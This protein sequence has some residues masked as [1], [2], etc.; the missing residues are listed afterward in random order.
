MGNTME[1]Y[2]MYCMC[3]NCMK[4]LQKQS[5]LEETGASLLHARSYLKVYDL[6]CIV[7]LWIDTKWAKAVFKS[8]KIAVQLVVSWTKATWA[9]CTLEVFNILQQCLQSVSQGFVS[10]WS[11]TGT[12]SPNT[13][14]CQKILSQL[15]WCTLECQHGLVRACDSSQPFLMTLNLSWFSEYC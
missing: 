11:E 1:T 10:C 5:A 12:R 13:C 4:V 8:K 7:T 15:R 9:S 2:C 3:S 14:R 6:A